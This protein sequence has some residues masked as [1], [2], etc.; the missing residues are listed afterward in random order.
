MFKLFK[1]HP[2]KKEEKHPEKKKEKD[3]L[4]NIGN[5]L[6]GLGAVAIV[7]AILMFLAS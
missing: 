1:K 5:F 6:L 7:I 3:W 2:E 4:G